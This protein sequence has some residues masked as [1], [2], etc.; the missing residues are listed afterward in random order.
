MQK[1]S[2]FIKFIFVMFVFILLHNVI[3]TGLGNVLSYFRDNN[4][5]ELT[6]KS[7]EKKIE[8]LEKTILDY[9][10]SH[11]NLSIYEESSY[12]LGKIALR[13]IYDFYNYLVIST[14]SKV[15]EGSAVINEDGLL[16]IV[17]SA[18]KTT[19]KVKLLTGKVN[20]SVK[21]GDAYG[22][23]D[24]YDRDKNCLIVHNIINYKVVNEGD[25]VLTSGLQKI[26]GDIKIGTVLKIEKEGVEQILYVKPFVDFDNL[27]YLMVLSK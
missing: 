8:T 5:D 4:L 15:E 10:S 9:E 14:A 25:E 12:I 7:Y 11:E 19:A 6:I 26:D 18:N 23:L 20:I 24:G 22:L 2:P 27:N 13:D 16:G 17:D 3:I 21:V 1:I